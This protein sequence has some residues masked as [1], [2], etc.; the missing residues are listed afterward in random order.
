MLPVLTLLVEPDSQVKWSVSRTVLGQDWSIL[1]QEFDEQQSLPRRAV[2]AG[3]VEGSVAF[4]VGY[5]DLCVCVCVCVCVCIHTRMESEGEV[6][7]YIPTVTYMYCT[8]YM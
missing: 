3:E 6:Y 7:V 1:L 4:S 5:V 8:L 2:L